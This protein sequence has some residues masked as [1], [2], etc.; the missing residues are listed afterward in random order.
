MKCRKNVK[1]LTAKEKQ[2]QG[3]PSLNLKKVA[4]PKPLKRPVKPVRKVQPKKE[5]FTMFMPIK[6]D[7]L[8]NT[9]MKRGKAGNKNKDRE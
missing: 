8:G 3:T 5:T 9:T 1:N 7:L 4:T 6:D 2:L